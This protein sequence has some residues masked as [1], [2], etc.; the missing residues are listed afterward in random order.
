[1]ADVAAVRDRD[2]FVRIYLSSRKFRESWLKYWKL[3]FL[4]RIF[5]NDS[6]PMLFIVWWRESLKKNGTKPQEYPSAKWTTAENNQTV[7]FQ[8]SD[9]RKPDLNTRNLEGGSLGNECYNQEHHK[10]SIP[11]D[12]HP[13]LTLR[14]SSRSFASEPAPAFPT[15]Y[16]ASE[17]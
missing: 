8:T 16:G 1:M 10:V 4:I 14:S 3:V 17:P 15:N 7:V 9:S 6:K 2:F 13:P 11:A 5:N 12:P